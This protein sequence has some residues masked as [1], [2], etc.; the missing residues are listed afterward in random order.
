[1]N[2]IYSS[3][4]KLIFLI[5]ICVLLLGNLLYIC[6][7]LIQKRLAKEKRL[8]QEKLRLMHESAGKPIRRESIEMLI[9][10]VCTWITYN[11]DG[12]PE[13]VEVDI[14]PLVTVIQ[15]LLAGERSYYELI[16]VIEQEK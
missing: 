11:S 16:K 8:A 9:N 10:Q 6:Y 14:S 3:Q 13:H 5:V 12:T 2:M 7:W 15:K 1:M 4:G